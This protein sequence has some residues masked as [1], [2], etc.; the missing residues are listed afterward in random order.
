M[1][2]WSAQERDEELVMNRNGKK[3]RTYGSITV[4]SVIYRFCRK[5]RDT[6]FY[7]R[8]GGEMSG[9]LRLGGHLRPGTG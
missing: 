6:H 1:G 3:R 5:R 9:C 8:L 2:R 7:L 4:K